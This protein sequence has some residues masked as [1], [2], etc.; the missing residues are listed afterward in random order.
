MLFENIKR[1]LAFVAHPDD[2][3]LGCGFLLQRAPS[4]LV[5]YAVDGAP[6]G[7]GFERKF[8]T[9]KNYSELRF[10]EAGR[11]LSCVP[12]C[13]LQRLQT[14]AGDYYP[15]RHLFQSLEPAAISL[16]SI[17]KKFSPDAIVSHA[18]E[19][20]HIDHDACSFLAKHAANT[21]PV[22]H[23]EFPLYWQKENG[24]DVF[25]TFRNPQ[26]NEIVLNPSETEI[27]TKNVMLAQYETQR[28][29]VAVF[30]SKQERFRLAPL[31]DYAHPSWSSAYSG[32]W[33]SRIDIWRIRRRFLEFLSG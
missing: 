14:L 17:A 23:F 30:A 15:D 29:T 2:E 25:Q 24:Q 33:R 3:T 11:A 12:N 9:L 28:E 8:G 10:K 6:A 13:S 22:K 1:L 18:F 31:Y 4:A 7:Y 5:V 26:E 16:V 32:T 21:L 27:Q 19:G 20:G